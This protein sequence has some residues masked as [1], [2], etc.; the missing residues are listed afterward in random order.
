M[1]RIFDIS[2][3]TQ[4]SLNGTATLYTCLES[5]TRLY[6]YTA[7]DLVKLTKIIN[8]GFAVSR[9]TAQEAENAIIQYRRD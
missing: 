7:A 8:R 4:A 9:A 3:D 1:Q 6:N 2:Q 5:G